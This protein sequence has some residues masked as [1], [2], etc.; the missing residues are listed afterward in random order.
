MIDA[1]VQG[2]V[3]PFEALVDRLPDH[4]RDFCGFTGYRGPEDV[5]HPLGDASPLPAGWPRECAQAIR[6][7]VLDVPGTTAAIVNS[8][9]PAAAVMNPDLSAAFAAAAN[10][11]QV[12]E[13]L[14][15]DDRL[16]ASIVL[17]N[18]VDLAV[19]EIE[20]CA[21]DRRFVQIL[22]PVRSMMP[23]GKRANHPI[24]A[25][26]AE[27][28]LAVALVFGGAGPNP[29]TSVGWPSRY[30]EE[31]VAYGISCQSQIMSIIGE[32]V[33]GRFPETRVV[34]A[35]C[36]W[37]W[38]PSLMWR[39]DKEWKGLRRE[40]PW[41]RRPP[42]EYVREHLRFTLSPV[43][44]PDAATLERTVEQL[45]SDELLLYSSGYPSPAPEGRS[46]RALL[47]AL[48][49]DRRERIATTNAQ[50]FYGADRLQPAAGAAS[51]YGRSQ[52]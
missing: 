27:H 52:A 6:H 28:G 41:V 39:M 11:W 43:E 51:T 32:G 35:G 46:P 29:P 49:A 23:V 50:H 44:V 45:G 31:Y 14:D 16:F 37:A 10:D 18:T 22:L 21:A 1:D 5:D 48:P 26:A 36:G 42:S 2:G 15:A 20:R 4:V 38:A 12:A 24:F 19:Q 8:G 34:C 3:P 40:I 47:D 30:V 9:Y 13:V 25:A 7:D 17:P 33:L